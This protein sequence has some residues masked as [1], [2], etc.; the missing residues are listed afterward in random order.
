MDGFT[1][2]NIFETKGQEYLVI[3]VFLLLLIPFWLFLFKREKLKSGMK[4]ILAYL[5]FD[6]LRIPKG[7]F[8]GK[9]HT[10]AF[11]ER[12]G[13][14]SMGIDDF[15]IQTL[16]VE[17][18]DGILKEGT[19]LNKG[20][21]LAEIG[22]NEKKLKIYSPISGT[23]TETNREIIENPDIMSDDPYIDGWMVK[24]NPSNWTQDTQQ[25]LLKDDSINWEKNEFSRFKDFIVRSVNK[26]SFEPD[27][28]ILQDGGEIA[29]RTLEDLPIEIWTDFQKEFLNM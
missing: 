21:L 13:S 5:S 9:N 8:F 18:V 20:D 24:V 23:I 14:V 27:A 19:Q 7:V 29:G 26:Y 11:M 28:L 6:N 25:L 2:H 10:W 1:Y 22:S 15:L 16:G 17:R 4:R 12:N 3:I